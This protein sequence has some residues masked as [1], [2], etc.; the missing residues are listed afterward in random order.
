MLTQDKYNQR[1]KRKYKHNAH[2]RLVLAEK[3]TLDSIRRN[4]G[5]NKKVKERLREYAKEN[6]T[7][8]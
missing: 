4:R 5:K 8:S 1:I 6:P 3:R 2:K 7:I